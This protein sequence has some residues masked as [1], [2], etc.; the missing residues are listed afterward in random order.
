VQHDALPQQVPLLAIPATAVGDLAVFALATARDVPTQCSR[1][2]GLDRCHHAQLATIEVAG[3]GLAVG[4]AVAAENIRHL[5]VR[6]P[7]ASYLS[8]TFLLSS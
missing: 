8:S 3:I 5:E 4:L 1:S 2:A 6:T 7:H